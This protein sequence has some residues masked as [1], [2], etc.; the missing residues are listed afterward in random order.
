MTAEQG[1]LTNRY[2]LLMALTPRVMPDP[3]EQPGLCG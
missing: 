3:L 1:D 2:A